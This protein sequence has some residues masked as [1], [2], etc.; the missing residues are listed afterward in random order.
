MEIIKE[1]NELIFEI[2]DNMQN[3]AYK[4][5]EKDLLI[6]SNQ[7]RAYIQSENPN[8]SA[9]QMSA[10]SRFQQVNDSINHCLEKVIGFGP[11]LGDTHIAE[12]DLY[13]AIITEQ[14]MFSDNQNYSNLDNQMTH[15]ATRFGDFAEY[16][17]ENK[18]LNLELSDYELTFE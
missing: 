14:T 15:L 13:N 17:R 8:N 4:L 1:T 16:V 11:S 5:I 7:I 3:N 12:S 10:E 2:K 9:N 18:N 6:A